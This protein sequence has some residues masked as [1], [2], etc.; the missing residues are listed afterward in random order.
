MSGDLC[1][2]CSQ[3]TPPP[4]SPSGGRPEGEKRVG[5][6]CPSCRPTKITVLHLFLP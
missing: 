2:T 5:F 4:P 3:T 1:L 6:G